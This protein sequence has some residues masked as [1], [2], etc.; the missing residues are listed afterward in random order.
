M[1]YTIVTGPRPGS[2]GVNYVHYYFPFHTHPVML[3]NYW[4][5]PYSSGS[6]SIHHVFYYR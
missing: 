1:R 6:H 2:Y 4:H 3:P 5:I